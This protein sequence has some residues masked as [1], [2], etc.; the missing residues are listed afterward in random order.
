MKNGT[1]GL[2]AVCFS[3][4]GQNIIP[5][6]KRQKIKKILFAVDKE[7]FYDTTQSGQ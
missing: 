6:H 4:T 2:F 7:V 5:S 3:K 1:Y